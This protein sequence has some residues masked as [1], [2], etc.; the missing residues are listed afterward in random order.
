MYYVYVMCD[1]E[2]AEEFYI[3]Y[4]A[5]LKQRLADHNSG[6]SP[7]TAGK[8]WRLVYY[9]AYADKRAAVRREASLKKN[10]RMKSLLLSRVRS[11]FQ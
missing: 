6:L 3:G 9:E 4:S 10:R 5:D 7:S 1:A 2:S 11:S 8:R